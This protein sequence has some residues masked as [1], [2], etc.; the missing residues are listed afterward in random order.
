MIVDFIRVFTIL[1]WSQLKSKQFGNR[2]EIH[3]LT[4]IFYDFN[5]SKTIIEIIRFT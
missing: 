2:P 1:T 3:E 5:D 4:E